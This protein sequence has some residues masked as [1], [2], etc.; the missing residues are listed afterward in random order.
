MRTR[1]EFGRSDEHLTSPMSDEI[2]RSVRALH[3]AHSSVLHSWARRRFSDPREAEEVVQEAMVLA[4]RKYHQ[5]DAAKGSERSWMFGIVRNVAASRHRHNSKRFR[6]ARS[7]GA[8]VVDLHAEEEVT[9]ALESSHI[10]DALGSLSEEHRGVLVEAYY[11]GSRVREIA[12]RLGI[13]EGTVKSRMYYGLRALRAELEQ[14][15]VVG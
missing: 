4:W 6:L 13:A 10:R 11:R 7:E 8:D 9:R 3:E 15:G 1:S 12:T 5:Y 2:E 14:R